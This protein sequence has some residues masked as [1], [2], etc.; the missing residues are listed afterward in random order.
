[1]RKEQAWKNYGDK[2]SQLQNIRGRET[3]INIDTRFMQF[4]IQ[5]AKLHSWTTLPIL[6]VPLRHR[7]KPPTPIVSYQS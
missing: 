5:R 3:G 2:F 7:D 6:P 1:M 4:K